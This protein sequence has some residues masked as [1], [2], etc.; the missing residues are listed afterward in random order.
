MQL[1]N[2]KAFYQLLFLL[3]LEFSEPGILD[4]VV[5]LNWLQTQAIAD[6][7]AFTIEHRNALHAIVAGILYLVSKIT[8]AI[9]IQEHILQVLKIRKTTS[10]HLLPARLFASEDKSDGA[11]TDILTVDKAALFILD[12]EGLLRKS[13]EPRKPFGEVSSIVLRVTE[14]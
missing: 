1:E 3:T 7:S 6:D 11:P 8:P 12:E 14:E 13:P 10:P 9:G 4:M 5:Y 2:L